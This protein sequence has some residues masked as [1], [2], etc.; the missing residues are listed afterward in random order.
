MRVVVIGAGVMGAWTALWLR[1]GGHDVTLI[2]R[3]GPGN[4]LGSSGD[5][6]R[7][8][9]SSHGADRHYPVW[10]RRALEQWRA[11][12][13]A[14]NQELFIEAGVVWLANDAQTFEGESLEA[15]RT[16]GIP[17]ERWSPDDLVRRVPVLN[18]AGVPWVL[19]E[20]EAG[21]LLA[22][23]GVTATIDAFES[24]GGEV[25][26]GRVLAVEG[27]DGPWPGGELGRVEVAGGPTIEGDAFVF[28]AGPWLP[29]LFPATIGGLIEPHRQDVMYFQAPPGDS[30]YLA[31]SMPAWIDFEG[32]FYGFPS[33]DGISIKACPDWL[34]PNERCDESAR[35]CADATVVASREVL[36]RRLPGIADQPVVRTWTCFYEVTPD[37]HFVIDRHPG[38]GDVWIAG[39]GTG[40]A[41]KHGPV[42]GEYLAALVTG[43][44]AV[45]A[46]LAPPDERFGSHPRA[47]RPSFRTSGRRPEGIPAG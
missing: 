28:A 33:F 2:D 16:L 17:V 21:A 31:P 29:D 47:A 40:H 42:I 5:E 27:P 39:G 15:L 26:T 14:S 8:T 4:R 18:P 3:H 44:R 45:V 23:R 32:S 37:A 7:I 11:L 20:P 1:R 30:R 6:S 38:L 41:F 12:G 24:M 46:E 22:R 25:I 19:F 36:R 35:E 34:G 9:R 43:D 10:Q 13:R